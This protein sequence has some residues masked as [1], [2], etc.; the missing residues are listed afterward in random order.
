MAQGFSQVPGVDFTENFAP[1]IDDATFR[2]VLSL[3]QKEEMKGYALDVETAFLHGEL[4]EEIYMRIPEGYVRGDEHP[5]YP[6]L[7][8]KRAIY[9][10]VQAARQWWKKFNQQIINLGF[11]G[12]N[13]DPCLFFK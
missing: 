7:K 13:V 5:N 11:Q 9:G 8:L 2:V 1:V 12:N 4:E 3:M 10:L 6:A